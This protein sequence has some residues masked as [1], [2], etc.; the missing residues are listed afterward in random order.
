MSWKVTPPHFSAIQ[1]CVGV[2]TAP[3]AALQK[4]QIAG[5]PA[6]VN[7]SLLP[8]VWK[9]GPEIPM[10]TEGSIQASTGPFHRHGTVRG[11][12]K[13]V[14]PPTAGG[15]WK[16]AHVTF[17]EPGGKSM[18]LIL[19]WRYTKQMERHALY[20]AQSYGG[21]TNSVELGTV[22]PNAW[23]AFEW[24]VYQ[25][26]AKCSLNQGPPVRLPVNLPGL[27]ALYPW[28]WMIFSEQPGVFNPAWAGLEL[29]TEES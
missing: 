20:L 19:T 9:F 29:L 11:L 16:L 14:Y 13:P 25:D 18:V 1:Q 5:K 26:G 17:L 24:N 28:Q 7:T 22:D 21:V 2:G 3:W 12:V 4:Q 10:Q 8:G 23:T 15:E 6:L 27:S